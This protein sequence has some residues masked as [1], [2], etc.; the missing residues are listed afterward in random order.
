MWILLINKLL[1]HAMKVRECVFKRRI[2]K[3]VKIGDH[4]LDL[5]QGRELLIN[6]Y[7]Q[8]DAGQI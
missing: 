3:K 1:K 2:G 8:A 5:V 7:G 4:S 6:L